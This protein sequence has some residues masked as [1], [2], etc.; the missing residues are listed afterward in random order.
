MQGLFITGTDTDVG[1]TF[2]S[3][4]LMAAAPH[5]VRYWKPIQTGAPEHCDT[6]TVLRL[7]ARSAES[8]LHEG[9]RF[10]EPA[11]PHHAA[12]LEN[13]NITLDSLQ[14][15][16][17]NHRG[18]GSRWVVEGAGGLLV[19]LSST[20]LM[21][22]LIRVLGLSVIL[23]SSTRLGTINHT[24]LSA[25][26]LSAMGVD[27]AGII[28]SGEPDPSALSG[29]QDHS[30]FPIIAQIPFMEDATPDKLKSLS[31]SLW[32]HPALKERIQ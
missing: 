1:K 19:P 21:T 9:L 3:A 5:N 14:E 17:A 25:Y 22:D 20:L 4:A 32:E 31:I 23:V 24:L 2:V 27:T 16:A 8:A 13:D 11:S 15:I 28:L 6:E 29:I 7:T 12:N 10:K 18:D 26:H 30:P